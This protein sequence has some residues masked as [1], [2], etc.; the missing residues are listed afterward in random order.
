MRRILASLALT[1]TLACSSAPV[2]QPEPEAAPPSLP[3]APWSQAPLA[4]SA[5]PAN[6]VTEW[7][8]AENRDTCAIIAPASVIAGAKAR[9]ANFYGGWAVAYDKP[10]SPGTHPSGES[11]D[12]CGRGVFGLAG[13]GTTAN[14]DMTSNSQQI[15]EWSDGSRAG[16]GGG[17]YGGQWLANIQIRNQGCLYQVWSYLGREH[18]EELISNLRFVE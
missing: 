14:E 2:A 4:R 8:K 17:G 9:R 6:Y 3:S 1:F 18:L 12:S 11:C 15:I 16:Y 13:A 7:S 10:G 5:V